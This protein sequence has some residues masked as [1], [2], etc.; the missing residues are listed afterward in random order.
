MSAK[1][2][3]APAPRYTMAD[4]LALHLLDRQRCRLI[5]DAAA[6][7]AP[8]MADDGPGPVPR[9]EPLDPEAT[10]QLAT[11][12]LIDFLPQHRAMIEQTARCTE[13][14]AVTGKRKSRRALTIDHGTSRY[15]TVLYHFHADAS[16]PLVIAHEF[17][18][19]LQIRASG[20]TFV[21]PVVREICAFVAEGALLAHCRRHDQARYDAIVRRWNADNRKYLG[22]LAQNLSAAIGQ[23]DAAY[24]YGWNYPIARYLAIQVTGTFSEASVWNLFSGDL[25]VEA[26]MERLGK[27]N[28]A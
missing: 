24:D 10:W 12:A 7:D 15:P 28:T 4:W 1:L 17:G 16:D 3:H 11:A 21:P 8:A 9:Y 26:I 27:W 25:D 5:L 23:Q 14:I 13:R 22:S 20:A 19:A 2:D 6:R 18:H